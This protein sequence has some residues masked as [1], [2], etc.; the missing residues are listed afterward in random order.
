MSVPGRRQ[1]E[2]DDTGNRDWRKSLIQMPRENR[3]VERRLCGDSCR[4]KCRHVVACRRNGLLDFMNNRGGELAHGSD[5][6]GMRQ[7]ALHLAILPLATGA[8]QSNG[9]WRSEVPE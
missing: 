2:S 1:I 6:V 9:G 5:A 7:L 4:P 3:I 8:L